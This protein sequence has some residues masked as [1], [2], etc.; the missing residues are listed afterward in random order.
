MVTED[1]ILDQNEL[2]Q[3]RR[4]FVH[5]HRRRFMLYFY[6]RP[7]PSLSTDLI[8]ER[9]FR[10]AIGAIKHETPGGPYF[11][12]AKARNPDWQMP[13]SDWVPPNLRGTV[14]PPGPDNPI[15]EAFIKLT[16]DGIGIHGTDSLWSLGTAASHGCIRVTPDAAIYL[17][18]RLD[19][20][21]P[22]W[23]T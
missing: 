18:N 19:P 6:R 20:G 3:V 8:L 22:V 9:K 5:V 21:D 16:D 4:H 14:V 2:L 23:V 10:I 15:K 12:K 13:F 1:D 11:V 7:L 17:Y